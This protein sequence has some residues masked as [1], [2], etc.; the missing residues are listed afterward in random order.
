MEAARD[1]AIIVIVAQALVLA[2]GIFV[3][4]VISIVAIV[5][6]T[7][8]IRRGLRRGQTASDRLLN[9]TERIAEEHI[10]PALVR[11]E[12]SRALISRF[13]SELGI[14]GRKDQTSQSTKSSP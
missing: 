6:L 2:L 8:N 12:R 14:T 11:Y 5:E 7:A 3:V 1:I 9:R 10:L 13:A 4:G